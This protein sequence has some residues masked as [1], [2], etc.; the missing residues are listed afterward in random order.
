MGGPTPPVRVNGLPP[1]M[2]PFMALGICAM[3]VLAV[4]TARSLVHIVN[5]IEMPKPFQ[6]AFAAGIIASCFIAVGGLGVLAFHYLW[7]L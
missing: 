4:Y 3:I 1:P 7:T 2:K 5:R 6:V